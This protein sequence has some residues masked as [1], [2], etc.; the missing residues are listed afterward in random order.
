MIRTFSGISGQ[1]KVKSC[2]IDDYMIIVQSM[3]AQ[4]VNY[5]KCTLY[6]YYS[7]KKALISEHDGKI[8]YVYTVDL[9]QTMINSYNP[10]TV[11]SPEINFAWQ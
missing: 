1:W 11:Q 8:A 5:N 3:K 7:H 6:L 9:L 4:W 2:N 10:V